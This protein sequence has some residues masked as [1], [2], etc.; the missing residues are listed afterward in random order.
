MQFWCY[1]DANCQIWRQTLVPDSSTVI[2]G[3]FWCQIWTRREILVL[4]GV[5]QPIVMLVVKFGAKRWLSPVYVLCSVAN[6]DQIGIKPF[7]KNYTDHF[8][9]VEKLFF[10]NLN[11]MIVCVRLQTVIK[12]L[13][14]RYQSVIKPLKTV[15]TITNDPKTTTLV[16]VLGS[17]VIVGKCFQRFDTGLQTH[18]SS[19]SQRFLNGLIPICY[20]T[21]NVNAT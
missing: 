21:W 19:N 17:L 12:P 1:R 2:P 13:S 9:I 20:R 16:V 5:P 10:Q 14:K 8:L 18:T 7:R 6:R 3:Q 11:A 15:S 4:K